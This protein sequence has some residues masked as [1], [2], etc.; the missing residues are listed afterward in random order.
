[1]ATL[2]G[3]AVQGRSGAWYYSLNR[4]GAARMI[5]AFL[6]PL[7]PITEQSFDPRGLFD[8]E[9]HTDFHSIYIASESALPL[10]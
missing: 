5:N 8:R 1:M 10:G 7:A 3:Q 6:K 9:D 4:Q 2:A